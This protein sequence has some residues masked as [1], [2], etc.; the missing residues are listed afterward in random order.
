MISNN[1]QGGVGSRKESFN[2]AKIFTR[3]EV[4]SVWKNTIG[5]IGLSSSI[6]LRSNSTKID[7]NDKADLPARFVKKIK[8]IN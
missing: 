8:R 1:G 4:N 5:S 2:R 7:F 6:R 3:H